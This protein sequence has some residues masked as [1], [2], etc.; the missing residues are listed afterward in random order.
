MSQNTDAQ[1]RTAEAQLKSSD[2]NLPGRRLLDVAIAIYLIALAAF[3]ALAALGIH[4]EASKYSATVLLIV[5][6]ALLGAI[7]GLCY[8][9]FLVSSLAGVP[10]IRF[11]NSLSAVQKNFRSIVGT[12]LLLGVLCAIL[13]AA[14]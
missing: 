13:A 6:I 2:A 10:L 12:A 3:V 5:P 4:A 1:N 11:S 7:F 14:V 9:V 8:S